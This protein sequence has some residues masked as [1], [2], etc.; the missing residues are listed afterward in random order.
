MRPRL[1]S[2]LAPLALAF[3]VALPQ[4]TASPAQPARSRAALVVDT[5]ST[6]KKVCLRFAAPSVAS[7]A[8]LHRAA[9]EAKTTT[10]AGTGVAVCSLCGTGCPA[11]STCLT[12]GG[13]SY[14]SYWRADRGAD[15]YTYAQEG[16]GRHVVRDGDVEGW[17]W[18]DGSAPPPFT[19]V[20]AVCDDPD[21]TTVDLTSSPA[22]G[23]RSGRDTGRDDGERPSTSP[24]QLGAFLAVIAGLGAA[25]AVGRRRWSRPGSSLE[26]GAEEP[27]SGPRPPVPD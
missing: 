24:A 13:A 25:A 5:G 27:R 22:N 26:A 9:V 12:C 14:W 19:T 2:A 18:G 15:A 10:F 1:L 11:D 8:V 23:E 6:V 16:V 3:A 4:P 7:L 21:A 17:R 20:D